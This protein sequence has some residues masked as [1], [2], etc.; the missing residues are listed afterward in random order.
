MDAPTVGACWLGQRDRVTVL[1]AP[2]APGSRDR[3]SPGKT[4][5]TLTRRPARAIHGYAVVRRTDRSGRSRVVVVHADATGRRVLDDVGGL[6]SPARPIRAIAWSPR[7]DWLAADLAGVDGWDLLHLKGRGVDR[8][9]TLAAGRD[10]QL[11]GW[12]C[13]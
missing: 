1:T 6:R 9:R 4:I 2:P 11:S 5:N 3:H 13:R 12:C 8:I 10:A 7:G